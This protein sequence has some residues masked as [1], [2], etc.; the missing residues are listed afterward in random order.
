M[1]HLLIICLVF[2]FSCNKANVASIEA[3]EC[4]KAKI[5][6]IQ[7]EPVRN[8]AT[9]VWQYEYNGETVYYVPPYCCDFFGTVY[10]SKCEIICHPD[11][12]I[13]GN[14][15]GK[16]KNFFKIATNGKVIWEDK[17]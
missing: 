5:S 17:R 4:I 15:D 9:K 3:P 2:A 12:G 1:K 6:E 10:N 16:C 13:A 8:P 11:G 14:G 7:N